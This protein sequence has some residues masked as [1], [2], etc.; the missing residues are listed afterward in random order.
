MATDNTA[1]KQEPKQQ[2]GT[3][4]IVSVIGAGTM[5]AGIAIVAASHNHDV[6]LLDSNKESLSKARTSIEKS[7]ARDVEKGRLAPEVCERIKSHINYI[8]ATLFDGN[9]TFGASSLVVEAIIEDL[10]AKQQVFARIEQFVSPECVLATNTSSL[11]VTSVASACKSPERVLGIHFFN[12]ANLMPLVEVIPGI[13]SSPEI[14]KH[15]QSLIESWG[16]VVVVA[17]DTP[18]FIVN[19]VARPFY[20]E[21]L[22]IVEEQI[23]DVATVDWAMTELGGF[24]MG[25]FTLMDLIGNDVN[26]KVTESVF[27]AFYFDPRYRPSNLQRRMVEANLLGRKTGRGYYDYREGAVVPEPTRNR[28]LGAKVFER[29]L[30]MLINE[31]A[32]AVNLKVA[33]AEDIDLAMTK[34]VN[35]PK[36]LLRW[37]QEIGL[38]NVLAKLEEL[39]AEYCED[40]Y[41][42]SP[43]LRRMA[44]EGM[45][46]YPH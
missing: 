31:A 10:S 41:R 15:S 3:K 20:G 45:P 35:Y 36:G 8:D 16:K 26:Y 43:L 23:A 39:Y 1:T 6:I 25:P 40:R 11:S 17:K 13:Q 24:R 19:R 14:V 34:G 22:R 33:S 46:F 32:E 29:I 28:E 37:G 27:S 38:A 18:G 44:K 12:P 21:A 42:P 9:S 4:E 30:C 5:G 7:L 2:V